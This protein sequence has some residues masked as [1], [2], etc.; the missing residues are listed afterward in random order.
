MPPQNTCSPPLLLPA[1][2]GVDSKSSSAWHV[3]FLVRDYPAE[4]RTLGPSHFNGTIDENFLSQLR[5]LN[6]VSILEFLGPHAATRFIWVAFEVE[7]SDRLEAIGEARHRME[8]L[9]DGA[10][11]WGANLLPRISEF[12]WVGAADH[13]D[14][15][16]VH[17]HR[18]IWIEIPLAAPAS[19]AKW[20]ERHRELQARV[21]RFFSLALNQHSRSM[22]SLGRQVCHSMRMFRHGRESG[23]WGV[24]FICKFCALEG[25]V[26]GDEQH[27]KAKKLKRRL[28]ALFR[29][30]SAEF[31]GR[32]KKLWDFRSG[33]VHTARAFDAGSLNDGAALGVHLEEIEHLFA[34]VL[35]FALEQIPTVGNVDDLWR[36]VEAY[37]LPDFVRAERPKDFPRYAVPQMEIS[38]P[39][40]MQRGGDLLRSHLA[41]AHAAY[42]AHNAPP[43]P[44]GSP[45]G[46][47]TSGCPP[48]EEPRT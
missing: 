37:V 23:S 22:T 20:Q 5:S 13:S 39:V 28:S 36:S 45:D 14:L 48:A 29:D 32:I 30:Q 47:P 8:G 34:G 26:C 17:F 44:C 7:A 43:S 12:V 38:T 27:D 18:Q 1:T 9:L 16:I 6:E 19:S 2:P 10:S 31:S 24:E 3:A 42:L 4:L 35:V 46:L 21:N 33:A 41:G 11:F 15:Q 40:T 25:L